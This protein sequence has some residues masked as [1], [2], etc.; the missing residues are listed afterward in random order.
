MAK[1][2]IVRISPKIGLDVTGITYGQLNDGVCFIWDKQLWIKADFNAQEAIN[3][4]TGEMI[5][6]MCE[7]VVIPVD[8]EIKWTKK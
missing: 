7:Y 1:K 5:S 8:V 4:A 6:D 3:L 2:K